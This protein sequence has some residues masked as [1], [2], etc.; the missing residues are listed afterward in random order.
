M[1]EI[2]HE[3][4]AVD[5]EGKNLAQDLWCDAVCMAAIYG[6][7]SKMKGMKLNDF[8]QTIIK[9]IESKGFP[10][11]GR[12]K[13]TE[14]TSV[15]REI[16]DGEGKSARIAVSSYAVESSGISE[17]RGLSITADNDFAAFLI[18]RGEKIDVETWERYA[19]ICWKVNMVNVNPGL[20]LAFRNAGL[21][22]KNL[23]RGNRL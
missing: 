8:D 1:K 3:R 14:V 23:L 20:E 22:Q 9:S 12:K 2:C 6:K 4:T 5:S 13:I 17:I 18:M 16:P 10:I 11:F 21:L 19:E 15:C 7:S